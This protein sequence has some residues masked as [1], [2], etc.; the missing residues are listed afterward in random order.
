MAEITTTVEVA[1]G[2]APL[3]ADADTVWT[4]VTQWTQVVGGQIRITRGRGDELSAI[5]PGTLALTLDN[6]DGRFT[7]GNTASPYY[8]H[9]T[10]Y[11]RIRVTSTVGA[12]T[13]SRFDGHITSWPT[14]WPG[15]SGAI[16]LATIAASDRLALVTR[17]G[18]LRSFLAEEILL[19]SPVDYW[20]LSEP[21][22]ASAAGN[23][24]AN[25]LN[26]GTLRNPGGGGTAT[27]G[28]GTGPAADG[29]PALVLAPASSTSG[30]F[31][32]AAISWTQ[33]G[34]LAYSLSAWVLASTASQTVVALLRDGLVVARL[35]FDAAKKLV[36]SA[37]AGAVTVT[38]PGVVADGAT[39]H[40]ALTAQWDGAGHTLRAYVDG[41]QVG[42]TSLP[43]TT[44]GPRPNRVTIGSA[45]AGSL[46]AGTISHVS[47]HDQVL[48]ADR[49]SAIYHAGVDGFGG[50]RSDYR[51]A[52][53]A[54]Y[55][56]LA[57]STPSTRTGVWVL[58]DTALS[59]LGTSTVLDATQVSLDPGA[60]MVWGQATGGSDVNAA[61][62][63]VAGTEGGL[64]YL[65]RSGILRFR[66]R[67]HRYNRPDDLVV[68]AAD[69]AGGLA[70]VLDDQQYVTDVTATT[71]DG[72]ACRA[73]I[74]ADV[75]IRDEV[76]LLTRDVLD[77]LSAASWR[78]HRYGQ[79]APRANGLDLD[80]LTVPDDLAARMLALDLSSVVRV[81]GLP[82]QA[83]A[84]SVPLFI[85]G[86][87]ETIDASQYQL[88]CN[89]SSAAQSTVWAL[90]HPILS[91]L[92]ETTT[93]A[94]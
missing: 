65:D 79:P 48:T 52:R 87:T 63:E 27:F 73:L 62:Q 25:P 4:D 71:Q 11:R 61:L 53:L 81:T 49:I 41:V 86:Y 85:E 94:Y 40:V 80:L 56:G 77:A 10:L 74:P 83:P 92:D 18:A 64:V 38:S 50:E 70:F 37:D 72:V 22:G 23:I 15:G 16:G 31:V 32:D 75:A 35:S 33:T 67:S 58:D 34:T 69:T 54:S 24:G 30:W 9:V 17:L 43:S 84:T 36:A 13:V 12:A 91:V 7:P 47:W 89:T 28:S 57:T 90:D 88:D 44:P 20:P 39:H 19:G 59:V 55:A 66:S 5:Q 45:G 42:T 14:T 93:L 2:S 82:D 76:S 78:V 51:V 8:P 1:F 68:D 60:A 3:A 21:E 29:S 6:S 26:T 46:L